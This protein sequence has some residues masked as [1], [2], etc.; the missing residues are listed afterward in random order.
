MKEN[1]FFSAIGSGVNSFYYTQTLS[2]SQPVAMHK[3]HLDLVNHSKKSNIVVSTLTYYFH[4]SPLH[5]LLPELARS[6]FFRQMQLPKYSTSRKYLTG[7]LT[8]LSLLF[9]LKRSCDGGFSCNFKV[10]GSSPALLLKI[11]RKNVLRNS[12]TKSNAKFHSDC[13][14]ATNV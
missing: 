4:C 9:H 1:I 5:V 14:R 3:L 6:V 10:A 11:E 7:I 2:S 13:R 12:F 8:K